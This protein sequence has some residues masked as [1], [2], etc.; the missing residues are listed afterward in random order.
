MKPHWR[1]VTIPNAIGRPWTVDVWIAEIVT[2]H[3]RGP[4]EWDT[5]AAKATEARYNS[6]DVP[7]RRLPDWMRDELEAAVT[8]AEGEYF[9]GFAWD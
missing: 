3:G 2:T 8:R 5:R 1:E 4:A 6:R 9:D 7:I